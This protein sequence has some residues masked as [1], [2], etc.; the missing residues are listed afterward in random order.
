MIAHSLYAIDQGVKSHASSTVGLTYCKGGANLT[1]LVRY[2]FDDGWISDSSTL[3]TQ[4]AI[5]TANGSVYFIDVIVKTPDIQVPSSDPIMKSI[6]PN[7]DS[8]YR[9]LKENPT[10]SCIV[11]D[12]A[13]NASHQL[14]IAPQYCQLLSFT[15]PMIS[16]GIVFVIIALLGVCISDPIVACS[17]T[18]GHGAAHLPENCRGACSC[19]ANA[20]RYCTNGVGAW[21]HLAFRRIKFFLCFGYVLPRQPAIEKEQEL[22]YQEEYQDTQ[23]PEPPSPTYSEIMNEF[24]GKKRSFSFSV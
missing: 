4:A 21:L 19:L 8:W 12:K 9:T 15:G 13:Y 5:T 7:P 16:I 14:A 23:Q 2:D 17:I 10:F 24:S 3:S 1:R 11:L 20:W 18:F 22:E 6:C